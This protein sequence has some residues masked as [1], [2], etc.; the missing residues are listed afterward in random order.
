P[1]THALRDEVLSA[2]SDLTEFTQFTWYED[3]AGQ[4][5]RDGVR[6]GL[7]DVAELPLPADTEVFMC[8]P[9]PFMRD[10]RR[11]LLDRGVHPDRIHY[12]VFGPDLWAQSPE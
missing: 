4:A 7:L 12:E 6:R 1:A 11:G 10:A 8:G 5:G 3:P 9:L 2:G